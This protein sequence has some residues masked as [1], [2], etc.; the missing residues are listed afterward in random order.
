MPSVDLTLVDQPSSA[1][2]WLEHLLRKLKVPGSS[3][4]WVNTFQ[5][6]W[7]GLIG[8]RH[9]GTMHSVKGWY[10]PVSLCSN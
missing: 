8:V 7:H 6:V 1:A 5:K 2:Q 4:G 3:P 9:P 10:D